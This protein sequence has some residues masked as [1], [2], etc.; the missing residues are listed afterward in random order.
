MEDA[1]CDGGCK[2]FGKMHHQVVSVAKG[3]MEVARASRRCAV[4]GEFVLVTS[5]SCPPLLSSSPPL[6][7]PLPS[8]SQ[9]G[10]YV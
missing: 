6:L 1:R 2:A 8:K 5:S 3:R 7:P 4:N 10:R 9:D